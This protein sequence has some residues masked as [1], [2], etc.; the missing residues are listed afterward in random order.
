[1]KYIAYFCLTVLVLGS[2][3]SHAASNITNEQNRHYKAQQQK[4]EAK[5]LNNN[6]SVNRNIQQQRYNATRPAT[7]TVY[8]NTPQ[9]RYNTT[10][11]YK[12]R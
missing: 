10:T 6:R 7:R 5:R 9:P 12:R 8:R 11:T 3:L 4:N 1:M 2:S